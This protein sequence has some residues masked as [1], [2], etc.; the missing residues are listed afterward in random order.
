M[1]T[2]LRDA[3][4]RGTGSA[5]RALGV[6]GPVGGKTGTT[7]E[8]RDAWFVGFSNS[9]VVGVW[10]GFD[11][12]AP[13]GRDAYGARVALPIW[14]DFM[15]RIA[16]ARPAAEFAIPDGLEAVEL[17]NVSYLRPVEECSIYTEYFKNGDAIPTQLCPIHRG[18]LKQ[19][20]A[21]AVEGMLRSLGKKAGR[22]LQ[23]IPGTFHAPPDDMPGSSVSA[24]QSVQPRAYGGGFRSALNTWATGALISG[25]GR[26][27]PARLAVVLGAG[28]MRLE[29]DEDGYFSGTL[30]AKP[31]SLYQFRIDEGEGRYP[32]PASRFQPEG[33]HGPSEIIDPGAFVDRSRLARRIDRPARSCTKCTSERSRATEPG[34]R[35]RA[36]CRSWRASASR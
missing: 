1:V 17:C 8:Y 34:R 25:Y 4:D 3:I 11:Q 23:L 5:V 33:P 16:R 32:D 14:A 27:R 36:N 26:L 28:E 9:V 19:R 10:V 15:K 24:R 6:R 35:R 7:D 20:A 13:I 12:P 30:E 22:N 18:S 2:M 21:R 29:R 31:G